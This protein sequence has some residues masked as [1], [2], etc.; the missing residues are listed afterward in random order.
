L[1]WGSGIEHPDIAV[2]LRSG[3]PVVFDD[4]GIIARI[5]GANLPDIGISASD[6]SQRIVDCVNACEGID[7]PVAFI[8]WAKSR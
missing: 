8:A 1:I 2:G 3:K 6:L 7:D 5:R 4:R